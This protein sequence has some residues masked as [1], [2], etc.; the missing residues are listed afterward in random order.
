MCWVVFYLLGIFSLRF[1][2]YKKIDQSLLNF[3]S[4]WLQSGI[5]HFIT[6]SLSSLEFW[7]SWLLLLLKFQSS[8]LIFNFA[9]NEN[10]CISS[11]SCFSGNHRIWWRSFFN[12]GSIA[13]YLIA[14]SIFYYFRDLSNMK[15]FSSILLYFGYMAAMSITLCIFCGMIGF[16]AS[17]WFVRQI[18]SSIRID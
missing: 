7:L 5:N 1:K 16:L 8:S 10:C 17:Y 2:A 6:Y 9:S 11:K 4:L 12:T 14:Y 15:R 3:T 13:I 18:Y